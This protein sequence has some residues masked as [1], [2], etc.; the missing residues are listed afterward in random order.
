MATWMDKIKDTSGTGLKDVFIELAPDNRIIACQTADPLFPDSFPAFASRAARK[1]VERGSIPDNLLVCYRHVPE[2]E[3]PG[4]RAW[5]PA[6]REEALRFMVAQGGITNENSVPLRKA[7]YLVAHGKEAGRENLQTLDL[8]KGYRRYIDYETAK[9]RLSAGKPSKMWL[10]IVTKGPRARIF[11]DGLSGPERLKGYLQSVADRFYLNPMKDA[12]ELAVYRIATASRRLQ[13][14][15]TDKDVPLSQPGLEL[16]KGYRPAASFDL[17]PENGNLLR[18]VRSCSLTLSRQNCDIVTL[19]DIA[20]NGYAHLAYPFSL[21]GKFAGIERQLDD[22]PRLEAHGQHAQSAA[23]ERKTQEE[24]RRLARRLLAGM[25]IP[26]PEDKPERKARQD[27]P[28][29]KV[30]RKRP[31]P[32]I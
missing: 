26:V 1:A 25:G 3:I 9:E 2:K 14:L 7:A 15:P 27:V 28:P 32:K 30:P 10:T 20:A 8:D 11:N 4:S 21:R 19:Q 6:G 24:A 16:L 31:K 5:L 22:I 17:R 13:E 29:A 12:P 18:F 23:L